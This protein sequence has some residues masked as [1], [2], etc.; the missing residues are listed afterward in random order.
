MHRTQVAIGALGLVMAAGSAFA[1]T[2]SSVT[3]F[4]QKYN[5]TVH[6]L[7]GK[8]KNA[9]TITQVTD[10]ADHSEA[11]KTKVDFVQGATPDKD[12]LF[13]GA[14]GQPGLD[15]HDQFYLLTG[16]D[17]ATG[18][19]NT[20]VSSATQ[21]FGGSVATTQGGRVTEVMWINDTDTGAKKDK[22]IVITQFQD[23]D[24]FRFYDLNPAPVT[25]Y[26]SDEV[27]FT[28]AHV[29]KGVGAFTQG[30]HAD[31]GDSSAD[32]GDPNGPFSGFMSFA[33][34]KDPNLMLATAQPDSVAASTT[35][36]MEIGIFDIKADKFL[37][38]L[39]NVTASLP[40]HD[41]GNGTQVDA[42]P[43]DLTAEAPDPATMAATSNVYLM[44]YTD[45]QPGGGSVTTISSQLL[46]LQI[47]TPADLTTAKA[48]DIKVKTLA[49]EDLLK[50][51]L[52]D[53]SANDTNV[54]YGLSVGREISAGKRVIYLTDWNGNLFTL[55]PQ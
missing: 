16:S 4:G 30:P 45:P 50:T 48:G 24:H 43:V 5:V 37:P 53:T 13:A 49:T 33:R 23:D 38:A 6:S 36:G 19:F 26:L 12:R 7:A 51:G 31:A 21:Y 44:I 22:N 25:D 42:T 35:T 55:T 40:Q 18:D 11:R 39:S 41:D 34:T 15:N 8:Y 32:V 2:P 3:L 29:V 54:I 28:D 17:A 9:V 46:R 47:D 14:A 1:A 27:G 10:W 52:A 20:Q